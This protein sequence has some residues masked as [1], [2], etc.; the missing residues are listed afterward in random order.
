MLGTGGR[1]LER[2]TDRVLG[3]D[4]AACNAYV[5]APQ[6]AAKVTCPVLVIAG[7]IDRMTAPASARELATKFQDGRVVTLANAGHLMMVEQPDRTL[8]ALAEAV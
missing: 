3:T 8:D 2:G 7:E 6:A 4:L 5:D 1:L